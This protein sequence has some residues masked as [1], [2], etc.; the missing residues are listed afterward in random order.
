MIGFSFE[1]AGRNTL[2]GDAG[3][4]VIADQSSS[5]AARAQNYAVYLAI[6]LLMIPMI[7]IIAGDFRREVLLSLN[8]G[9]VVLSALWSQNPYATVQGSM[10]LALNIVFA[11]YLLRRFSPNDFMRLLMMA[12]TIALFSSLF[13]VVA[14]PQYGIMGR[15]WFNTAGWQGIFSQKNILGQAFCWLITPAF[16]VKLSGQY[17]R[18]LR[19]CYI[20]LL[21]FFIA[22]SR[23]TGAWIDCVC[24]V[25]SIL[26]M[27]QLS[28][29]SKR[30]ATVLVIT[31]LVLVVVFAMLAVAFR[32]TL[33]PIFGKDTTLTGRTLIYASVIDS[34]MK[35]PWLGYGY[36]AFW[37]G[38]KG[39]S[40]NVVLSTF[41][42][43]GYAESGVLEL[44][45]GV[46]LI[47]L[48]LFLVLF[49][50]A[51]GDAV[52]C[53]V[54]K[55]SPEVMWYTSLLILALVINTESGKLLY[56]GNFECILEY[57][58]FVALRR[59]R[60]KLQTQVINEPIAA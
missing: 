1:N 56:I 8:W 25:V 47:G 41:S 9:F 10:Y 33:L 40:A 31:G 57:I 18:I 16:F 32:E 19:I 29:V 2:L 34:I 15:Q 45:L 7:R 38:L 13:L 50:R 20:F 17:A 46:G 59:E 37:T 44:T 22:M 6:V 21:L 60:R 36:M 26:V 49:F 28:R 35:R 43:I 11:F 58:V 51:V 52:Y 12:G 5:F 42:G 39:E 3:A 27:K 23:S 54:R 48:V 24:V 53:L 30:D 14:M 4:G 55:P